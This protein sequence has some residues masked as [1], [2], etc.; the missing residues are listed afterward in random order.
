MVAYLFSPPAGI[1]GTINSA[2]DATIE[3][4]YLDETA[5]PEAFGIPVK[6]A[7]DKIAAFESGD[8]AAD[9]YGVLVRNVPSISGNMTQSFGSGVPNPETPQGVMRRGYISVRCTVGTPARGGAVYV[10]VTAATGKAVGD[11]EATADGSN[12]VLIPGVVWGV[13]DKDASGNTVISVNI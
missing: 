12:N 7:G 11:F 13:S 3:S 6:L 10:R 5:T 2:L 1:P 4:F 8:A 9:F